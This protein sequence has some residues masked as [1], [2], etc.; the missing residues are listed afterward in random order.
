M[1]FLAKLPI[2]LAAAAAA[3]AAQA[4]DKVLN[5]YS[6]R[7][8]QTDEAMYEAFTKATGVKVNVINESLDDVQPKASVAANTNQGPDMFW[9]LYSLPQLFPNACLE[10][11]DVADYLVAKGVPFRE[12]YQLVGGLVKGCLAEGIL[13]RDRTRDFGRPGFPKRIE[14]DRLPTAFIELLG[15][16]MSALERPGQRHRRRRPL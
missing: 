16:E 6:A 2:V 12:A 5:L 13:L 7:H 14:R 15:S 4:Q 3:L 11:S 8:Y 10:V 9:G 1:R